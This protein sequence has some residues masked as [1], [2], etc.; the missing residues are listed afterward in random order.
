VEGGG[1]IS[2]AVEIAEPRL[3]TLRVIRLDEVVKIFEPTTPIFLL[4]NMGVRTGDGE[5][6]IPDHKR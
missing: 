1:L 6:I 5:K 3:L 4:K 2:T